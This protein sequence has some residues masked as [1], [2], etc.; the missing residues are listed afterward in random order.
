MDHNSGISKYK[1]E[2]GGI[3]IQQPLIVCKV[4]MHYDLFGFIA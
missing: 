2:L 3:N 1:R 4:W